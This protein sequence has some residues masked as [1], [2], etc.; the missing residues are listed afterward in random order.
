MWPDPQPNAFLNWAV[1]LSV[2]PAATIAGYTWLRL[3]PARRVGWRRLWRTPATLPALMLCS[4]AC[5]EVFFYCA[6]HCS[7]GIVGGLVNRVGV[8]ISFSVFA[9][10]ADHISRLVTALTRHR[11]PEHPRLLL[12]MIACVW[13]IDLAAYSA[14]DAGGLGAAARDGWYRFLIQPLSR[15]S[16]VGLGERT[17]SPRCATHCSLC[18]LCCP[19]ARPG[20]AHVPQLPERGDTASAGPGDAS[21]A[22][23]PPPLCSGR[24]PDSPGAG[25]AIFLPIDFHS[26]ALFR[27]SHVPLVLLHRP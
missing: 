4:L 21:L 9:L 23:G 20:L 6:V 5:R 24:E 16:A 10:L 14:I 15:R 3:R 26:L 1:V 13:S 7:W 17:S 8:N 19:C 25:C 12:A 22:S 2:L 18:P 11:S 27:S